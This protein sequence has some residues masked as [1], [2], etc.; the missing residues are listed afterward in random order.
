[1]SRDRS[2]KS[3]AVAC[4]VALSVV[5]FLYVATWP[6]IEIKLSFIRVSYER[7]PRKPN[8]FLYNSATPQ[9]W[10]DTFYYPLHRL[11]DSDG[12]QNPLME[13]WEWWFQFFRR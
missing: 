6:P 3:N 5:L 4:T 11:R 7:P 10:L 12:Q 13:Y 9:P 2:A 1:M 8:V